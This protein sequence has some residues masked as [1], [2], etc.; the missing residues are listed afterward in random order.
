MDPLA[1]RLAWGGVVRVHTVARTAPPVSAAAVAIGIADFLVRTETER[2][3]LFRMHLGAM[4]TRISPLLPALAAIEGVSVGDAVTLIHPPTDWP[5]RPLFDDP[6]ALLR[7]SQR[8]KDWLSTVGE[9]EVARFRRTFANPGVVIRDA[10]QVRGR[11]AIRPVGKVLGF[12]AALGPCLLS[13]FGTSAL[14]KLPY[15]LP[16][17]LVDAMPG[18][19]LVQIIQHPIFLGCGYRVIRVQPDLSDQ[20]PVITFRAPLVDFQM[21]WIGSDAS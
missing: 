18:R 20:L 19:P 2:L 7:R 16:E 14:L 4:V 8:R 11:F 6:S 5:W 12:T 21:P 15:A 10:D 1:R 9:W 17:T 13:A 3:N